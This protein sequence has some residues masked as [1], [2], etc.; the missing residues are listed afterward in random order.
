LAAVEPGGKLIKIRAKVVSLGV[1]VAFAIAMAEVAIPRNP[2]A[3]I[4]RLITEERP[5]VRRVNR[6]RGSMIASWLNPGQGC[7]R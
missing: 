3:D 5:P 6:V 7:V 4:L 2:F 1:Y